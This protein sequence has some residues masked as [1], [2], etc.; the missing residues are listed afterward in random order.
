MVVAIIAAMAT[1]LLYPPNNCVAAGTLPDSNSQEIKI[2]YQQIVDQLS[3]SKLDT[4]DISIDA[5]VPV[6]LLGQ[7]WSAV[8]QWAV[9][10]LNSEPR[11]TSKQLL[12]R[13]DKLNKTAKSQNDEAPFSLSADSVRFDDGLNV[14]F[15]LLLLRF[16]NDAATK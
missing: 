3:L 16:F 6:D 12:Q 8:G 9:N 5:D 1:G 2:R 14:Y 4:N 7:A 13:M 11:A 15:L 10:Y